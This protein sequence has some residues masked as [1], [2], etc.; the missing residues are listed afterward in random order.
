MIGAALDCLSGRKCE[1]VAADGRHMSVYGAAQDFSDRAVSEELAEA[2]LLAWV[3]PSDDATAALREALDDL[4]IEASAIDA[5][6]SRVAGI[7]DRLRAE[8]VN[9]DTDNSADAYP[10][11]GADFDEEGARD[12]VRQGF[13]YA[14]NGW[15]AL[16]RTEAEIDAERLNKTGGLG[17]VEELDDYLPE[18]IKELRGKRIHDRTK[19]AL[20][21]FLMELDGG[22]LGDADA[23]SIMNAQAVLAAAMLADPLLSRETANVG[24]REAYALALDPAD[25]KAD[26][27][28]SVLNTAVNRIETAKAEQKTKPSKFHVE[29]FDDAARTALDD[30]GK[31]LVAGLLDEGAMSVLYGASNSG[32][33]FVALDIAFHIGT[34]RAWDGRRV[35]AGL[36]VYIAAEGGQRIKRRVAALREHYCGDEHERVFFALVRSSVDLCTSEKDACEIGRLVKEQEA[37]FGMKAALVVVDTLSRAMAGRDENSSIDMG[38]LVAN[39]DRVRAN[40]GAHLMLIHHSGKDAMRG[41]RGHSLLRAATDTEL[42]VIGAKGCG[43]IEVKKQRD[44]DF[45]PDISFRLADVTLGVDANGAAVKSAVV[46]LDGA[47][48]AA[49]EGLSCNDE[50]APDLGAGPEA[51]QMVDKPALTER[52]QRVLDAAR[53]IGAPFTRNDMIGAYNKKWGRT[54]TLGKSAIGA[55]LDSMR[56]LYLDQTKDDN[57]AAR[58]WYVIEDDEGPDGTE[59]LSE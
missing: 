1:R 29:T 54:G 3:C 30:A 32:K 9:D 23:E 38:A 42:E 45:A 58:R 22:V 19:A 57:R 28:K 51:G 36:V 25:P 48:A 17:A 14:R 53:A 40:T 4:D 5:I 21:G 10:F 56:G 12:R 52:Q 13:L 55:V 43:K 47:T 7:V 31:P 18:A 2:I 24:A 33:T 59:E 11:A 49:G 34:G 8:A 39:C 35:S 44:L 46:M 20:D 16:Y 27:R 15:G 50:D 6:M 41:A 37:H 26:K